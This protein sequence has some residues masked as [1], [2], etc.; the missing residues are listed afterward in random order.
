MNRGAA[1]LVL[2][3]VACSWTENNSINDVLLDDMTH[4]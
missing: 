4:L 1:R 3:G 2:Y